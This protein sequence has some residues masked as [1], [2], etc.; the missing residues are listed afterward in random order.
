MDEKFL[1]AV[2]TYLNIVEEACNLLINYIEKEEKITIH[3]K[4]DLYNFLHEG[5]R[6]EFIIEGRKFFFHGIG[7]TVF[8]EDV[9]II[10]WDFG[11]RSWWCGIQPFKMS[12]TLKSFLYEEVEYYDE[13]FIKHKCEQYLLEK[14][15]YCHGGQYYIDLLKL[16]NKKI[17]FPID[18]S[19]IDIEYKGITKTFYK[20]RSIEKFI[21]K[22]SIIYEGILELKNNYVLIFYKDENEIVRIPYNDI[23]YPESAVRIMNGEIIKPH[24]VQG[25]KGSTK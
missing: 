15:M 3:N 14:S 16:R 22:S 2:K 24:I 18:Y 7:C 25:W 19:R 8:V 21:R 12:K 9:S 20:S 11:Y 4:Y 10:D 13:N 17:Q 6:F 1:K 23:A 5:H